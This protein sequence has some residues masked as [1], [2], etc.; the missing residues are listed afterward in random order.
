[1]ITLRD[2]IDNREGM[3]GM[4]FALSALLTWM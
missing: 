3:V 4:G 1:M 2:A